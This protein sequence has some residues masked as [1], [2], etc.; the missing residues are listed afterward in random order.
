M[1]TPEPTAAVLGAPRALS[2]K[3]PWAWAI[4]HAGKNIENRTWRT[5]YRGPLL[6]HAGQ[7]DDLLGW[8]TLDE[9]S[10]PLPIDPPAGGIIGVVDLIDC[11]QHHPSAWAMPDH[12][13][14][15]FANPRPLPFQATKGKLG[16]FAPVEPSSAVGTVAVSGTP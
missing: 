2:I 9:H 6:I 3:Q 5:N 8:Q 12:W 10:H 13:H 7:Q 16:L 15:V 14:W 1:T 4:I 11:V